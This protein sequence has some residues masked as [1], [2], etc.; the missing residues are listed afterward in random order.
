[1]LY[2]HYPAVALPQVKQ[3][4]V[5]MNELFQEIM[6][7]SAR[8]EAEKAEKLGQDLMKSLGQLRIYA[9]AKKFEDPAIQLHH[10]ILEEDARRIQHE[11]E[12]GERW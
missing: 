3:E 11:I 10:A 8:G 4:L 7:L 2:Q 5:C 1:M 9:L 6:Q 12:T